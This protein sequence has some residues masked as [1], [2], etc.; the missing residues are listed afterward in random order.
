[1][2]ITELRLTAFGPFT[3]RILDLSKGN[4]GLHVI[5]G[6]NEA[7]KSSALRALHA[8][9]YGIPAQTD[10][11]FLHPYPDLRI[12]ARLRHSS[13]TEI[14]FSRRKA[15]KGS[16]LG[17]GDARLD[18][19]ALDRFLGGVGL[20]QFKVFWAIDHARLVEGGREILDGRGEIGTS[21][22]AAGSGAS[23]LGALRKKI[24]EEAADLFAPRGH[25]RTVNVAV[26]RLRELRREQRE[27]AVSAEEWARQDAVT[28]DAATRIAKLTNDSQELAR[29]RSRLERAKRVLPLLAERSELRGR[30]ADLADVIRLAT[31][32]PMRR[33]DAETALRTAERNRERDAADV[34]KQLALVE[35]LGATP[36]LAAESDA[37]N[38]LHESLGIHRKA[39][40]DRPRLVGQRTEQLRLA[41]R[42]LAELRPDLNVEGTEP[43]RVFVGR[44]GRIQKLASEHERFGERLKSARD[45]LADAQQ[46]STTLARDAALL[47]SERNPEELDGAIE[48]SRRGSDSEAQR[49]KLS[50]SFNRLAEQRDAVIEKL[51]LPKASVDHL[52]E[53]RVPTAATI[54]RFDRKAQELEAES[55]TAKTERQ[56]VERTMRELNAKIETA[57]TKRAVPTDADLDAARSRR[58]DAFGLL[59]DHWEKNRDVAAEARALLGKGKLIDLYPNAVVDADKVADR[60]RSEADR[61]A[62]LAQQIEERDRLTKELEEAEQNDEARANAIKDLDAEWRAEWKSVLSDAPQIHDARAWC[63][64]LKRLIERAEQLVETRQQRDDLD[65]W[66]SKQTKRL[67]AA[68]RSLELTKHPA[69]GL[70]AA[71]AAAEKLRQRIEN[72]ARSLEEHARATRDVQQAIVDATAAMESAQ[73]DL[74]GWQVRW[75]EATQGMVAGRP[76]APDD[77]LVALDRV[78]GLF[79]ALDEAAKYAARIAGID[80]DAEE[81]QA[82]VRALSA[83]LAESDAI[84]IVGEEKW[85]D[86]LH[87]RLAAVIQEEERRKQANARLEEARKKVNEDDDAIKAASDALAALRDEAVCGV[88]GDLPTAEQR[89]D[90]AR[91][92]ASDV[93]RVEKEILR[94]GDRASIAGIESEAA[95]V[96]RDAIDPRLNAITAD[97]QS[98][99]NALAAARDAKAA[100]QAETRRMEGPSVAAEKAEEV[101]AILARLRDGVLRHARLRMAGTLLARRIDDYRRKNQ[102]PLLQR[103]GVLFR[104]MT[105]SI[106]DRLEADVEEERLILVG[107]RSS[108]GRRV[109]AHGMSEGTRDQLFFALRLAARWKTQ[110]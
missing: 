94:S 90:E 22:F 6:P 64:D 98:I 72:D 53:L 45:Q 3:G 65:E 59:R 34:Q 100:A 97:L 78:D 43:L 96:D 76:P 74:D 30:L 17:P 26:G 77:A 14:D 57:H 36:A 56:R 29:E 19:N 80:R 89:S 54:A 104:E 58:D 110:L 103:A 60:L 12:G 79:R 108:D 33:I 82:D 102:V 9:L 46:E 75:R 83:R 23:H 106:F 69:D 20:D 85:V 35:Q 11:A 70:A 71:T 32:F 66:I 47:P 5:F 68:V 42:L 91:K 18:D 63:E 109:P 21:L 39:L 87:D 101:Q 16:L 41:T 67:N 107:M 99:D 105:L 44:R 62:E 27:S 88:D 73:I 1:V 38:R 37:V 2:K 28:R 92:C 15:S 81:F 93:E 25:N 7:G 31:D 55:R 49:L 51:R 84:P 13:G 8:L 40:R 86:G 48:E 52:A 50:R 24:E 4:P 95:N 10:D 61:V